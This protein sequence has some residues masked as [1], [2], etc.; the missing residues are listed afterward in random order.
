MK[1]GEILTSINIKESIN[2]HLHLEETLIELEVVHI[3]LI[4]NHFLMIVS[5]KELKDSKKASI[6]MNIIHRM[7][8]KDPINNRLQILN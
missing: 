1:I 7:S 3:Q 6:T 2:K 5:S 8:Y 4:E